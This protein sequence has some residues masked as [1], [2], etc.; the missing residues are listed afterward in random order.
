ME[1][2]PTG[3]STLDEVVLPSF[4]DRCAAQG[5]LIDSFD[6]DA[7]EKA[8]EILESAEADSGSWD[9]ANTLNSGRA[10]TTGTD[11]YKWTDNVKGVALVATRD[12]ASSSE[13]EFLSGLEGESRFE[14]SQLIDRVF[15]AILQEC[16]LEDDYLGVRARIDEGQVLLAERAAELQASKPVPTQSVEAADLTRQVWKKY[17]SVGNWRFGKDCGSRIGACT[18]IEVE[19]ARS[20]SSVYVEA[21]FTNNSGVYYSAIDSLSNIERGQKA[22]F[23]LQAIGQ[24]VSVQLSNISCF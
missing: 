21:N 10:P 4:L 9:A 5:K 16:Q 23:K 14:F 7:F 8:F 17:G 11:S 15:D 20:C 3:P 24:G 19:F 2:T 1:P 6:A 22:V 12:F 13:F 18:L